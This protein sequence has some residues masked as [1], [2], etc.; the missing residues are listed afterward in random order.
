MCSPKSLQYQIRKQW[1]RELAKFET[2]KEKIKHL[3]GLLEE[4]GM[5]GH[6]SAAK[7][8]KIKDERELKAEVA[9]VQQ[10][11]TGWGNDEEDGITTRAGKS[12]ASPAAPSGR[13]LVQ[14]SRG[15]EGLD[16]LDDQ[17]DSE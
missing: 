7:A 10:G 15:F 8:K 16:F 1:K 3:R 2:P 12:T 13:K 11:A 6:Y 17:S 14:K 4:I 5:T 9:W